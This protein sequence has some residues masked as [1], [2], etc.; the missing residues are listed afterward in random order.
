MAIKDHGRS[1]RVVRRARRFAFAGALCACA[2]A[3]PLAG[4]ADASV[5]VVTSTADAGAGTLRDT[6]AAAN[7]GDTISIPTPGDYLVTSAELAVSKDVS[8]EGSGA[9]VRIVGDG[10]NRVFNVTAGNAT[11]SGLTVTGG[12]LSGALATGGGIANAAGTLVLRNVTVKGNSVGNSPSGGIPQGGGVYNNTGTLQIIDSTIDGNTAS[13]APGGGGIPEGG[14]VSNAEGSV[15]IIR[16]TISGNTASIAEAGGAPEGGGIESSGG[17]LTI[18]DSTVSGNTAIGGSVAQGG[19]IAAFV[20]TTTLTRTTVSS[21][22]ASES[23][24]GTVADGGGI[25]QFRGSLSLVNST[26]AANTAAG[27]FSEGG[28]VEVEETSLETTNTTIASNVASGPKGVGGNLLATREST[29]KPQNTIVAGGTAATGPNCAVTPKSA[30]QSQGHNLDSLNDC[31]FTAAGDIVSTEPLLGPLADNGGITQTM[32]LALSSRAIDAAASA[33]CPPTDQRGVL[34]PAGAGCD[35]GAFELATPSATSGPASA[36]ATTSAT[37]NGVGANPD[38]A[39]ASASFQYGATAAYGLL[40][41]AQAIAPTTAQAAIAASV[42]AL[43]PGALYHFRL[44]VKNAASTV[45]GADQT[46]TTPVPARGASPTTAAPILSGLAVRASS[47]LPE[48]GRGASIARKTRRRQGA[49]IS[50]SD[51]ARATTTFTVLRA[52][53][54]FR[55]G[56]RCQGNRP[57][58]HTGKLRRCTRYV[59]VGGFTHADVVGA[60]SFHFTGRVNG[61][62]L[63][64]G[65]YRLQ[66]RARNSTGQTSRTVTVGFRII[67]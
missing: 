20:T 23:G 16:T 62:P 3:I 31:G 17:Q 1:A 43:T 21:N 40:A 38:L 39:G 60:N 5:L 37:L 27:E 45:Y 64:V 28:G 33:A 15:T 56:K 48:S 61:A 51:S 12:G 32:A 26:I 57:R 47:V 41:P 24:A 66:A 11:L 36:V 65:S 25:L 19:G 42:G 9:A 8:I 13:V 7:P 6:L 54:G 22:A 46:F 53:P 14:G 35:I 58:R 63:P 59:N 50:Y 49:T 29:V 67:R 10:N 18:V 30:I 34:R 44:V 4:I 52:R 55:V 2:L